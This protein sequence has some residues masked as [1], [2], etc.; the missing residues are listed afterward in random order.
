MWGPTSRGKP[1]LAQNVAPTSP[2]DSTVAAA[3]VQ[4]WPAV[5]PIK[6]GGQGSPVVFYGVASSHDAPDIFRDFTCVDHYILV[7]VVSS[8]AIADSSC[9]ELAV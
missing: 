8:S 5:S 2:P 6:G 9:A 3:R 1:Y 7:C 4:P